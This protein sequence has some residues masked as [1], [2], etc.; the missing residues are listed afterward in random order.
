MDTIRKTIK[1]R[2]WKDGK[3]IHPED[4]TDSKGKE[5]ARFGAYLNIK[6]C[7]DWR[8]SSQG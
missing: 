3:E 7:H 2:T 8:R 1:A 6:R 4:Q 5:W